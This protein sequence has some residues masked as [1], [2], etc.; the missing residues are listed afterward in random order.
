MSI[1]EESVFDDCVGG[2]GNSGGG[3]VM[4]GDDSIE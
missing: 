4:D 1:V 2:V 3:M